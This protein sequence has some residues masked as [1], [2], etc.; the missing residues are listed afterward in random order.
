M[1]SAAELRSYSA[2]LDGRA[3]E[4]QVTEAGLAVAGQLI[5]WLDVDEAWL[6]GW[7]LHLRVHGRDDLVLDKLGRARDDLWRD[8]QAAR[9]PARRA[10]LLQ[11]NDRAPI[12]SFEARMGEEPTLVH[13][14]ADALVVEPPRGVPRLIPLSLVER[15]DRKGYD[16]ELRLRFLPPVS[17]GKFGPRTD[18]F[19]Q[20]LDAARRAQAEDSRAAY[21]TLDPSLVDLDAPDGWAITQSQAAGHWPALWAAVAG[22]SRGREVDL[23]AELAGDRLRLGIK[24]QGRGDPLTFA[25]AP[26]G[27]RVAVEG[28]D[29]DSRA[30]FVFATAD[31]DEL[32]VALLLLN[33][34]REALYLPEDQLGR[35]AMAVRLS[36]TVRWAR[37]ALVARV[38]HDGR[39]ES[40]LREAL[41]GP[42]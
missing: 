30:T 37:G 32:N 41:G 29:S 20:D 14:F 38:V 28:T 39:W 35:W 15:V 42:Q 8:L 17:F 4:L 26:V 40:K 7:A 10:G 12:D 25:L 27:G 33:F 22:Q 5:D 2:Q 19:E 36:H 21:A 6:E 3:V 18:E 13:L 24:S 23:L 9:R 16:F 11:S 1:R 34:R 31:P